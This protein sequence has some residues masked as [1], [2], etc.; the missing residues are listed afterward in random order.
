[1]GRHERPWQYRMITHGVNTGY[2]YLGSPLH[3][4]QEVSN[5]V[6]CLET[7]PYIIIFYALVLKLYF[8]FNLNKFSNSNYQ[9]TVIKILYIYIYSPLNAIMA[10]PKNCPFGINTT[11]E[12]KENITTIFDNNAI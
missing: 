12:L 11:I 9:L 8:N 10:Q 3:Y 1:M 7:A 4:K 5:T 6:R 2:Q